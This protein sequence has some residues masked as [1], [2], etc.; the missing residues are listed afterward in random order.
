MNT[1]VPVAALALVVAVRAQTYWHVPGGANLTQAFAA[2]APGDVMLL[3]PG[4]YQRFSLTKGLSIVGPAVIQAVPA[5]GAGSTTT[6]AVPAGQHARLVGLDFAEI[7]SAGHQLTVSGN[8]SL[9]DCQV[10]PAD[11]GAPALG[12]LGGTLVMQ[13]CLV[14]S[15]SWRGGGVWIS[16]GTA[17]LSDCVLHGAPGIVLSTWGIDSQPALHAAG[18]EVVLSHVTAVGGSGAPGSFTVYSEPAS[19]AVV[20]TGA[21][22]VTL[23]DSSLAGGVPAGGAGAPAIASSSSVAVRHARTSLS[24]TGSATVTGNVVGDPRLVGMRLDQG[25]WRGATSTATATAGTASQPLAIVAGF[26]ATPA[27]VPN[28]L[29]PVYGV[30]AG[31]FVT[32]L[33]APAAGAPVATAIAVPNAAG[34]V[35]VTL[36]LQ[37]LQFDGGAT[38]SASP[39]VG[40]VVR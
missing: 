7:P 35:G 36:W 22:R 31:L 18:G 40:G 1:T 10:G 12:Q 15:G 17:S 28:V 25:F 19:P 32:T 24:G 34:L 33:A 13:R 26:D 30:A 16:D 14:R 38:W 37:A 21:A 9:E 29:G 2:A 23:C 11:P 39:V 6:V 5:G 8:V 4:T 3:A 20:A 27:A